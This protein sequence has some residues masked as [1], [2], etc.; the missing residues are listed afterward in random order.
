MTEQAEDWSA[1]VALISKHQSVSASAGLSD[2]EIQ[3]IEHKFSFTFPPDVRSFLKTVVPSGAGFINWKKP[4]VIEINPDEPLLEEVMPAPRFC[5]EIEGAFF[6]LKAGIL[7]DILKNGQWMQE[8]GEKPS[9]MKAALL[10]AKAFLESD[11]VPKL[12]PLCSHRF[13]PVEPCESGNPVY[14][15]MGFDSI[16]YGT[17]LKSYLY[18][19]LLDYT[20][21]TR[22][23]KTIPFWSALI[24]EIHVAEPYD[25][26]MI[27][28][29]E[30][31][32]QAPENE[33][34]M[35]VVENLMSKK[36]GSV[37]DATRTQIVSN[38][39]Y[40]TINNELSSI[41]GTYNVLLSLLNFEPNKISDADQIV[42]EHKMN[43]L[44]RSAESILSATAHL[45][46]NII[47][48]NQ[49][50]IVTSVLER[51]DE[52]NELIQESQD[53]LTRFGEDISKALHP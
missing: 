15:I 6:H 48:S 29:A 13:I 31:G 25:E 32:E 11:K 9:D 50:K 28:V 53:L 8:F 24:G 42:L 4:E 33:N 17:D 38:E 39:I 18:N 52:Y 35:K 20:P 36:H 19:E 7:F 47:L 21:C 30:P 44:V 46:R 37:V 14:S 23:P 43:E 34:I 49:K 26:D 10:Q 45:K 41:R 51:K 12:I 3:S 27:A 2:T 1:V 16:V 5:N 40:H 22:Q